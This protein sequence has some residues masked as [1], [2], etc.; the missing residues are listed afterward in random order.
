VVTREG[1][2]LT[3]TQAFIRYL[4]SWMWLL[5]ALILMAPLKPSG[6]ESALLVLGWVWIWN[7]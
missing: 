1:R 6:T 2:L 5:L 3:R 7:C 4:L